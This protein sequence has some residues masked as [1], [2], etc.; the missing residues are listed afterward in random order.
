ML[1]IKSPQEIPETRDPKVFLAGS[2]EMGAAD[3]WQESVVKKLAQEQV[4]VLNPR[5]DNWD[6]GW[7]QR[8]DNPSFRQQVEWELH[9]LEQSNY[10]IMYFDPATKSPISLLELGLYARSGKLLVTCP[11]GFWR[12]GNVD[13]VCEMYH[14][15]QFTNLDTLLEYLTSLIRPGSTS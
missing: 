9:A 1:H 4:V 8:K 3:R 11:K 14:V 7:E 5:R 12:K 15:L 6:V 13:I 10:I 2:I